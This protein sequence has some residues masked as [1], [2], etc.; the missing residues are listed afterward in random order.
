A[1]PS[2]VGHDAA[3]RRDRGG[4]G[5]VRDVEHVARAG[6]GVVLDI[7]DDGPCPTWAFGSRCA[8]VTDELGLTAGAVLAR[9]RTQLEG[10]KEHRHV[11]VSTGARRVL[12]VVDASDRAAAAHEPGWPLPVD[13][14]AR[15]DARD[16]SDDDRAAAGGGSDH[17]AAQLGRDLS[18]Y[19]WID[20]TLRDVCGSRER[21]AEHADRTDRRDRACVCSRETWVSHSPA[22]SYLV[23]VAGARAGAQRLYEAGARARERRQTEPRDAY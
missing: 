22:A 15:D 20:A 6:V 11:H 14:E 23:E 5:A 19:Q 7:D 1:G 3:G 4:T 17:I 9:G 18:L 2:A 12:V 21:N 10:H 8:A 13:A 16:A